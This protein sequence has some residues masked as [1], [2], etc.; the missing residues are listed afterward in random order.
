M[1]NKYRSIEEQIAVHEGFKPLLYRCSAGKPTIGYGRNLEDNGI[2]L[3][4]ARMLLRND[5]INSKTDCI[6]IFHD[7]ESFTESRKWALIDM[8]FNLGPG[9]FRTF[10]KMI[11]AIEENDWQKA[12]HEAQNSLW[13][14]QTGY[15][16][17]YIVQLLEKG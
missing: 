4:E 5:V 2:S 3:S 7:W 10:E 16:A 14:H 12:A 1:K 17:V 11:A 8:R 9:S 6:R 15:R 13:Y